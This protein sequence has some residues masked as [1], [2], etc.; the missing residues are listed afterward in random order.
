MRTV[1][2]PLTSTGSFLTGAS[3]NPLV[4]ESMRI[5]RVEVVVDTAGADLTFRRN[6]SSTNDIVTAAT[7]VPTASVLTPPSLI[8][9]QR[10]LAAGETIWA[11]LSAGTGRLIVELERN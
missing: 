4:W 8:A 7:D 5:V 11:G 9:L 3:T 6:S 10:A 1:E 2:F